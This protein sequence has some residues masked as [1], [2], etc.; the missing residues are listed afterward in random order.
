MPTVGR[1]NWLLSYNRILDIYTDHNNLAFVF[2]QTSISWDVSRTTS[3]N[4]FR[5][6]VR[7]SSYICT[8]IHFPV[9]IRCG[10]TS[11]VFGG[12]QL[13]F[14]YWYLFWPFHR[15]LMMNRCDRISTT[16]CSHSNI[17]HLSAWKITIS[18]PT[19]YFASKTV[20][21]GS[22]RWQRLTVTPIYSHAYWSQW[23]SLIIY[24]RW[25]SSTP[26]RM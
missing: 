22:W 19:I 6:T 21:F 7:L 1:M 14:A 2:N 20:S 4:V 13:F 26:L 3:S 16:Y 25:R 17:L 23:I 24:Y 18:T 9:H 11:S 12:I 8:F 10:Q 5:W 15:H